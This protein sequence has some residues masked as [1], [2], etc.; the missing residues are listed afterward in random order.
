MN[1]GRS[2]KN[3]S[4]A[5][6][7]VVQTG[8]GVLEQIIVG[9]AA[10]NGTVTVYDNTAGSGTVITTLTFGASPSPTFGSIDCGELQFQTGLTVVIATGGNVTVVWS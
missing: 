4:G 10:A 5:G 2:Y 9:S 6:T 1:T 8:R 3:L 7:T